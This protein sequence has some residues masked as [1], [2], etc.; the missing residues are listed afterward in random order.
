M[1]ALTKIEMENIRK[2]GRAEGA[3]PDTMQ[4]N[5]QLRICI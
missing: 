2:S 3:I 1:N 5:K 4:K